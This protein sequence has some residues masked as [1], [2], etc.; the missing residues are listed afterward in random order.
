MFHYQTVAPNLLSVLKR[1]MKLPQIEDFR[2]VGG[3]GLSLQIGHRHSVD[4]DLFTSSDFDKDKM[5]RLLQEEFSAFV[6]NWRNKNGFTSLIDE[7]KVDFFN[8]GIPFI[9]PAVEE[10]GI[11]VADKLEIGAMKLETIT[12]RKDKKDFIDI[13]F[14]LNE[15]SLKE[16]LIA[17]REKYSFINP[18][19]ILESLTAVDYADESTEPKMMNPIAWQEV[20]NYIV[21]CVTNYFI[22]QKSAIELQQVERLRKAEELLKNKKKDI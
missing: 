11:I 8:W 3:T 5:L 6:L 13:Y 18:K 16:L 20:K 22:G 14:L 17:F 10:D 1:L 7:V 15:Y 4:L 19:M 12:T 2:L 9:K 21:D